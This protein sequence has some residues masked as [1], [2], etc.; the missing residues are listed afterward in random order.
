MNK[1]VPILISAVV[2]STTSDKGYGHG[3]ESCPPPCER[4]LAD[5]RTSWTQSDVRI[6]R[7]GIRAVARD[8]QEQW[9]ELAGAAVSRRTRWEARRRAM[10][11]Q[12]WLDHRSE[13][14]LR[15]AAMENPHEL[16]YHEIC[17]EY[18]SHRFGLS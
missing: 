9:S 17:L 4:R 7:E 5:P 2:G 11:C 8:A 13:R 10:L 6:H 14:V 16:S 12:A 18:E 15:L 1:T 3:R